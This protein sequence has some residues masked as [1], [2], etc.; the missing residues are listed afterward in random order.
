MHGIF[1]TS[2]LTRHTLDRIASDPLKYLSLW[3]RDPSRFLLESMRLNPPVTST[4][5]LLERPTV[6][7]VGS[8]WRGNGFESIPLEKGTTVS[9][10][11]P[12]VY[13]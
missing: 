4:T 8:G 1:A 10:K 12:A 9:C 13:Y 11:A 5:T 6:M 2:H 3:E 7:D